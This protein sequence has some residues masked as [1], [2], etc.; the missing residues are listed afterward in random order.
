MET[1]NRS[2]RIAAPFAGSDEIDTLKA[3]G[4]D[5]LY[6]GLVDEESERRWPSS[7]YLINRRGK[8]KSFVGL[9][10]LAQAA[11]KAHDRGLPVYVTLN[12]SYTPEQYSWLR[13]T[14]RDLGILRGIQGLIVSD[15]GLLLTL[16]KDGFKKEIC[17]ST[18]GTT[19]N[20]RTVDFYASLGATRVI[21]D[22][23]LTAGETAELIQRKKSPAGIEIFVFGHG[24]LFIDGYCS[25]FHC[26]DEEERT[27]MGENT[28]L[29]K[30]YCVYGENGCDRFRRLAASGQF[31]VHAVGGRRIGRHGLRFR[32]TYP[33]GCNLCNLFHLRGTPDITLKVV[34]RGEKRV[35][36]VAGVARAIRL[37]ENGNVG[38]AAYRRQARELFR[39]ITGFDCSRF[40][41]YCPEELV[42]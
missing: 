25:F 5:E 10:A 2:L 37:L 14:V 13:K 34:G 31:D 11:R 3:A 15:M 41:C 19:F 32:N 6:C 26:K 27:M 17:L 24:C 1:K 23:Q 38:R 22:R 39:T 42:R 35:A 7:F 28:Q 16:R 29:I 9:P 40:S 18:G 21:V 30:K 8:N 12:A 33:Y 4:A 20:A 36:A